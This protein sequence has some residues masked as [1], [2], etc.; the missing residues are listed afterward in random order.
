MY[1]A[2][3]GDACG[4]SEKI[5]R[6]TNKTQFVNAETGE[7]SKEKPQILEFAEKVRD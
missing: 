6:R 2:F 1:R 4:W 7:T 5:D 3:Q